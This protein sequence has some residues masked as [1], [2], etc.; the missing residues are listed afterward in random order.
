MR[1]AGALA[2][3]LFLQVSVALAQPAN[4]APSAIRIGAKPITSFSPSE[5]ER[6]RFGALEF[7]GG[8]VLDSDDK[9]FG[10]FSGLRFLSNDEFLA[11]NDRGRWLRGRLVSDGKR[12]ARIEVATLAPM[13]D[14]NGTPM[15]RGKAFDTES[16]TLGENG[17]VLVGIEA[18]HRVVRFDFAK[19]GLA[20][21][22]RNVDLPAF[23]R[24]L[25]H[26]AGLEGL[27]YVPRDRPLGGTLIA[28]AERALDTNGN[29]R[30]FL[31]GGP[32]PGEFTIRRSNDFDITDAALIPGGDVLILERSFSWIGLLK[33]RIRRI[34]LAEIRPGALVDGAV[35][36][37]A[38]GAQEIDNMEGIDV[39]RGADG[40][41]IVTV[42]SDDNFFGLQRTLL[43][44][45]ALAED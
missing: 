5:P 34:P 39:Q 44:R 19:R 17:D 18:V 8:L 32:T 2:S 43:L 40:E 12:P 13:L 16:I 41:T 23:V 25:P 28:F 1:R 4:D 26:N 10:G 9:R 31:I 45:F 22:A 15:L 24:G 21:R 42:I 37:E 11:I 35:L 20:S 14:A 29:L 38:G 36:L 3:L 30:A 6:T 27:V 7:L 33:M